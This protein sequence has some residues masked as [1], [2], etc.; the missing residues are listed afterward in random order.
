MRARSRAFLLV[1]VLLLT[2]I[3]AIAGMAFLSTR[4]LQYQSTARF[5]EAAQA[6]AL[7]RAGLE[8]AR[9]K[10][11]K[12]LR[13][14]PPASQSQVIF[15]YSEDVTDLDG[16]PVGHYVVEVDRTWAE[17]P[18][19]VLKVISTGRTGRRDRP[20]AQQTIRAELDVLPTDRANPADPDPATNPNPTLFRFLRWRE[21]QSL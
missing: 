19:G 21:S 11:Q 16:Q 15:A 17:A 9:V 10:L 13:F 4:S 7:A 3:L 1:T 18:Y 6:R 14:P 2:V 12:D 20:G 5:R 8:D